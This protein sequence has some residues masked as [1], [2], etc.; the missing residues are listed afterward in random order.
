MLGETRAMEGL[1]AAVIARVS[2]EHQLDGVDGVDCDMWQLAMYG[3]RSHRDAIESPST[4][5]STLP[6]T[7][8]WDGEGK[9]HEP[10]RSAIMPTRWAFIVMCGLVVEGR[11]KKKRQGRACRRWS[12]VDWASRKEREREKD[13]GVVPCDKIW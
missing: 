13:V 2:Y 6:S 4:L 10:L 12:R 11:W 1:A 7:S 9:S 5:P 8:P 3:R